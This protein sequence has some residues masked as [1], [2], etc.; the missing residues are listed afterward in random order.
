MFRRSVGSLLKH[1]DFI[2]LD[3][4][5]LQISFVVSF[6]LLVHTGNPYS[7]ILYR[8]QI[9]IL[10]IIQLLLILAAEP[11]KNI[12]RRHTFEE[13]GAVLKN[14]VLLMS[15]DFVYLFAVHQLM[16]L[17][18]RFVLTMM[19]LYF[20]MSYLAHT[21]NK[22]RIY[23][24]RRNN[25]GKRSLVVFT[26]RHQAD[27]CLA[28][29]RR[30]AY[31]EFFVKGIILLS[32]SSADEKEID[33][34]PV[35]GRGD[36]IMAR[37]SHEWV[38]EALFFL[39]PNYPLSERYTESLLEMG[40]T[41]HYSFRC[42]NSELGTVQENA[43]L[44]KI[45]VITSSVRMVSPMDLALKRLVDILGGLVGCILTGI[46]FIFVAPA[47]YI[48]SPGPIFFSQWRIGQ[49]GRK[50]KMY[51]FRSMYMDAEERKKEF[52]AQNKMDGLMFKMDDDP[53]IIGSEKRIR[54]G[55]PRESAILSAIPPWM[56]SLSSGM[57]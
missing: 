7:L 45:P 30:S 2:V 23:K 51:K 46:I 28:I 27:E 8:Y 21:F 35:Y 3:L 48:A 41:I 12:L 29:L 22:R 38:D 55:S 9:I 56:N 52:M 6:F 43:Y 49:N 42:M 33:G 34:I 17:S 44:G 11:Y 20:V 13:F 14:V 19:C 36:D 37:I 54:T 53:R 16:L 47:I 39:P 26:T 40:I 57:S 18:R 24:R 50:F 32:R 15:L 25:I 31:Q 10:N 5:C 4:I 1:L